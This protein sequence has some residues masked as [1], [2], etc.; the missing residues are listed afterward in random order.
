[1]DDQ[2]AGP[3]GLKACVRASKFSSDAELMPGRP[4]V[5]LQLTEFPDAGGEAT[6]FRVANPNDPRLVAD[7]LLH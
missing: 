6:Y 5:T 3:G 7:E 4:N 1:L 2:S